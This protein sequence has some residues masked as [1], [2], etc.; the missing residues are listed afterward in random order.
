MDKDITQLVKKV[1][2]QELGDIVA[3]E[4][5]IQFEPLFRIVKE[6]RD[7][8]DE[9]KQQ[10]REDREDINQ[11]RIDSST[12]IKQNKVIIDNQ[13]HQE[14]GIID[15]VKEEAQKIPAVAK[16]TVENIFDKRTIYKRLLDK[17][18]Q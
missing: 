17:F 15:A 16:Q 3:N 8:I 7:G 13:N 12:G 4:I 1:I 11:L 14:Q 6:N 2:E 10:I 9:V 18:K 5:K